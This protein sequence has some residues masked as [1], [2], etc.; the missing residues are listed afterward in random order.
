[1]GSI[2]GS[3]LG[4][5]VAVIVFLLAGI[6]ALVGVASFISGSLTWGIIYVLIAAFVLGA[7]GAVARKLS[8]GG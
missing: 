2:I 8:G 1:M 7:G 3:G 5:V 6:L 4:C